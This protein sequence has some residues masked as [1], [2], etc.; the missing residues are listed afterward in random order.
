MHALKVP[1]AQKST[2]STKITKITKRHK[3]NQ[4]KAQKR[5]LHAPKSTKSTKSTKKHKD[6]QAKTQNANKRISEYFL[7]RCFLGAF[8]IFVRLLAF[9]AFCACENF[10]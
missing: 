10:K 5:E 7:L 2:K 8:F 3:D 9:F 4:T 6:T 1:K